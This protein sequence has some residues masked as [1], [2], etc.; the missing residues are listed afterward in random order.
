MMFANMIWMIKEKIRAR[1]VPDHRSGPNDRK[2]W[3]NRSDPIK[4][5]LQTV[6]LIGSELFELI[7]SKN[8]CFGLGSA[9]PKNR[10]KVFYTRN[11]QSQKPNKSFLYLE[12]LFTKTKQRFFIPGSAIPKNR[13]KVFLPG[14]TI[15]KTNVL[16]TDQFSNWYDLFE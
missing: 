6:L 13:T 15:S 14:S 2:N 12:V 11:Y 3:S 8:F 1:T 5:S 7:C 9:T 10:T 4:G 16:W